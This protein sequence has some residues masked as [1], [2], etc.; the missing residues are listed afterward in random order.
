MTSKLENKTIIWNGDSIC[1]GNVNYGNWATRIASKYNMTFKNY[2]IGGGVFGETYQK[3]ASGDPRHSVLGTIDAMY[4]EYPDA[5]YV[6][7][8]GGS[9]DGDLI[10]RGDAPHLSMG[11]VDPDDFSGNYNP[12]TF[13]G[14]LE[15][16]FWK[17]LK[18]WPGKKIGYIVAQKMG[19]ET[20]S[21]RRR[22]LYFDKAVEICRKWG[23]PYV[24]LWEGC[25]INP[26]LPWMYNSEKTADENRAE[27][28]CYYV[29]GQHLTAK[30]YDLTTEVVD[31]WLNNL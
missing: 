15:T 7:F 6:I 17:A 29:D 18:Y 4:A 2:A 12:N 21:R 1:A 28:V 30:G 23:I 27:N 13:C 22:R 8:E 25:Y 31:S 26:C 24:D 10:E 5:D 3:S 19:T 20:N 14:T 16:V 9:N 11:S